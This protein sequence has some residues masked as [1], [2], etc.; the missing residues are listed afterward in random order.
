VNR[1]GDDDVTDRGEWHLYELQWVTRGKTS[2]YVD[3][4]LVHEVQPSLWDRFV[5]MFRRNK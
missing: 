5:N 1:P 3:G 4:R 2:M